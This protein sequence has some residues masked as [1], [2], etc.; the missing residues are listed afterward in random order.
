MVR[1]GRIAVLAAVVL[2][3]CGA[4]SA[5]GHSDPC[6]A[7]RSCPSDDHS[8]VWHGESCTSDPAQRL[9]ADQEILDEG[10]VRYYCHPVTDQGT[11]PPIGTTSTTT[12]STP[13]TAG[14]TGGAG[15]AACSGSGARATVAAL[16][17]AGAARVASTVT[18]STVAYLHGRRAPATL[19]ATRAA[20]ERRRYRVLGRIVSARSRGGGGWTLSLADPVGRA[21]VTVDFPA[22][23]CLG[24]APPAARASA[25]A[26][27]RVLVR[28]CHLGG[29]TGTVR[30]RGI[31]DVTGIGFFRTRTSRLALA[32]AVAVVGLSCR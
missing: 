13:T 20:D 27:R 7:D 25:A 26:A 28:A 6:H 30:R 23:A 15:G 22:A 4:G 11:V 17:D 10:G 3:A 24:A 19:G 8:Y 16:G 21:R 14:T 2:A 5:V 1:R 32:P 9:P 31:A 12:T 18:A 29:H